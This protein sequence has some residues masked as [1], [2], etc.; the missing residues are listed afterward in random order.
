MRL[1]KNRYTTYQNKIKPGV[2]HIMLLILAALINHETTIL[3]CLHS[4]IVK[5]IIPVVVRG[6]L[7]GSYIIY[8]I[9]VYGLQTNSLEELKI[10]GGSV[11]N[12]NRTGKLRNKSQLVPQ[13]GIELQ[14]RADTK[15][16][17]FSFLQV[18]MSLKSHQQFIN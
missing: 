8:I 9:H 2:I 5:I 1:A 11:A 17:K 3:S 13:L 15:G 16:L 14:I 18:L 7:P 10:E 12:E 6:C 4:F